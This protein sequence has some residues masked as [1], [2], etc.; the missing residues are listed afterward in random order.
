MKWPN[1]ISLLIVLVVNAPPWA[2]GD[3]DPLSDVSSTI[4]KEKLDGTL[5]SSIAAMTQDTS[6]LQVEIPK[7]SRVVTMSE[8]IQ[9]ALDHN[10]ALSNARRAYQSAENSFIQA[11]YH[12]FFPALTLG[13]NYSRAGSSGPNTVPGAPNLTLADGGSLTISG[14]LP[15][16]GLQYSVNPLGYSANNPT[17]L[18]FSYLGSAA[19]SFS[20]AL[21]NG[22][23]PLVSSLGW[24]QAQISYA[25]AE[26]SRDQTTISTVNSIRS[27]FWDLL[28]ASESIK[29]QNKVIENAKRTIEETQ[30]KVKNGLIPKFELFNALQNFYSQRTSLLSF[31]QNLNNQQQAFAIA[32]G[33]FDYTAKSD[34]TVWFI[35]KQEIE[36]S[37]KIKFK[38]PDIEAEFELALKSR[39]DYLTALKS[40]K[41]CEIAL[42][43][44]GN[45]RLPTLSLTGS[46]SN[47][48]VSPIDRLSALT[49]G[50]NGNSQTSLGLSLSWTI[51]W[52]DAAMSYQSAEFSI[53][54]Q[55]TSN[56]QL[57]G[58]IREQV[59]AA[60]ISLNMAYRQIQSSN[61]ASA[62]AD[63]KFDTEMI[64]YRL[65]ETP[66]KNVVDFQR[67]L[68]QSKLDRL[69]AYVNYKKALISLDTA[70]G[71]MKLE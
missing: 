20:I 9:L 27:S 45:Q 31:Q 14:S 51:P 63:A 43:L 52:L 42:A 2:R 49:S 50:L 54:S 69:N 66:Q 38:M 60:V 5:A 62:L 40:L 3:N 21:L 39:K 32:I 18:G 37:T 10:A 48:G 1:L 4:S 19:A 23:G 64:K 35:P 15:Y 24:E 46:M 71:V 8:A 7:N 12:F 67:D 47:S 30:I 16:L 25:V 56:L 11:R 13:V 57:F 28:A 53:I 61:L 41:S 55:E 22:F 58:S 70:L 59:R 33:L 6:Q 36:D 68:A 29:I 26:M 17:E 44:A 65:G 34:E